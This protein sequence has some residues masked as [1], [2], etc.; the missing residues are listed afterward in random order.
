MKSVFKTL[1]FKTKEQLDIVDITNQVKDFV[2]ESSI[3]NGLINIQTLHTTA[4]I[5]VNEHEPLLI[6][7]FKNHL[8]K[9]AATDEEYNHDDFE[10]RTVNMCEDECANGHAHCKALHLPTNVCLNIKDQ[11]LQLGTWQSI[12]LIELDQSRDR[13]IQLQ[14]IGE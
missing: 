2:K 1:D 6:E 12:L 10:R 9:L 3:N 11:G 13:K 7:D 5:F 4:T 8:K 14:I